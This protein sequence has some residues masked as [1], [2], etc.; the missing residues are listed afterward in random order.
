MLED[1]FR[2]TTR[3]ANCYLIDQWDVS[4]AVVLVAPFG[5][6]AAHGHALEDQDHRSFVSARR[7]AP[8]IRM[9]VTSIRRPPAT[10]RSMLA[11]ASPALTGSTRSSALNPEAT[12]I[13][14]VQPTMDGSSNSSA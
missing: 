6:W 9:R 5:R 1:F 3:V 10:L 11:V 2:Y 7:P 13:A 8:V 14:S 12:M 4:G